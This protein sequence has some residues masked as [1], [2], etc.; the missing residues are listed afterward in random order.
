MNNLVFS[1]NGPKFD[2]WAAEVEVDMI[3]GLTAI[4]AKQ[5]LAHLLQKLTTATPTVSWEYPLVSLTVADPLSYAAGIQKALERQG[6]VFEVH[7]PKATY[8]RIK[9]YLGLEELTVFIVASK[10]RVTIGFE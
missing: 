8:G 6:F 1:L 9:Q 5:K 3:V 2:K 4:R 10:N 7:G